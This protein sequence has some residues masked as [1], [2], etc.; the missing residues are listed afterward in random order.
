MDDVVLCD[1]VKD[2]AL[3]IHASWTSVIVAGVTTKAELEELIFG[4]GVHIEAKLIASRFET[5][6][7]PVAFPGTTNFDDSGSIYEQLAALTTEL[8]NMRRPGSSSKR[9]RGRGRGRGSSWDSQPKT[10][11]CY[12]CGK[13]GHIRPDCPDLPRNKKKHGSPA[14]DY[15]C[16]AV[17]FVASSK[18]DAVSPLCVGVEK[19]TWVV[20]SGASCH[21]SS[22]LSDFTNLGTST[23][24][25][26]SGIACEVKGLGDI[27]LTVS[28]IEGNRVVI[29]LKDVL[30]VPDLEE[31][32]KGS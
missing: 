23:M 30:F 13:T 14:E 18:Q 5:K 3:S 27:I 17:A 8:R 7:G 12:E 19:P 24:G 20:D 29:T 21:C 1:I 22:V 11:E 2:G 15:A 10:R 26:V 32:S 25:T 28:N 4:R 6:T 31:R 9:G 16:S